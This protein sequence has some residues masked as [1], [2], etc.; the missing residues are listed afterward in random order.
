MVK[1]TYLRHFSKIVL[2]YEQMALD[3]DV[4]EKYTFVY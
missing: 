1:Q 2:S 4:R 3:S